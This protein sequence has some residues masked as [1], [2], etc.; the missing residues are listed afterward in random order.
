MPP[1]A[2]VPV[3]VTQGMISSSSAGSFSLL[4]PVGNVTKTL[5]WVVTPTDKG[6]YDTLFD[7]LNPLNG[8]LPGSK[9]LH[10]MPSKVFF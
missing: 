10:L 2:L 3:P 4:S 9:V 6:K 7:S 1:P 5:N 8:K